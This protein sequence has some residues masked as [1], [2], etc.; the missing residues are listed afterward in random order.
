MSQSSKELLRQ[1]E[2]LHAQFLLSRIQGDGLA[3]TIE[4]E[5]AAFFDYGNTVSLNQLIDTGL[6]KQHISRLVKTVPF[7][8]ELRGIVVKAIIAAVES[9]LN[10]SANLQTLVPKKEYDKAISHYAKFEKVRMDIVRVILE[11]PIYSE[12]ISDVLYHGIKDYVM[13]ENPLTKNVPG[14]SSLMKLG[15]KSI[16]KAMPKLEEAAESTI[17]KFINS[18]LRSSVDLSERILNN[19]LSENNIR[20]IA[21]HFW[22]ALSEKQ[23]SKAQKYV[24]EEQIDSTAQLVEEFWAEIRMTEYLHNMIHQIVDYV[25]EHYGERK[26]AELLTQLGYDQ[27]FVTAELKQILPDLLGRE[28]VATYAEQ[29]IRDNLR[30][31]YSSADVEALGKA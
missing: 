9:E 29:R 25:F 11:S 17:K 5:S 13:K 30:D 14:V 26:L 27:A 18:N 22:G 1:L 24:D 6:L 23:F 15:A 4:R 28:A 2:Q 21:D 10:D 7:T 8:P 19:A 16:N 20:T 12:L 3:E 31:F